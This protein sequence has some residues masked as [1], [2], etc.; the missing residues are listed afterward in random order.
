MVR[1][2][3]GEA[4]WAWRSVRGR[5]RRAVL[6]AAIVGLSLGA[7]TLV[8]STADSLVFRRVPYA[9][10]DRLV[11]I[12]SVDPR[13]GDLGDAFLSAPLLEEWRKQRD[14]FVGVQGYLTKAVFL[15]DDVGSTIVQ[16]ADVTVGLIELLGV[17][18][19][20]GRLFAPG[21]ERQS[22]P[23]PVLIA[24]Q[25]ARERF[26]DPSAAVGRRIETTA[27]PLFV[28]GVMA[29]AF[30]FP[31]STHRIWRA[32]DPRG[33]LARGFVGT[34]SI[35]RVVPAIPI[36]TLRSVVQQRSA[37]I[38]R[39]AGRANIYQASLGPLR[40]ARAQERQR[41]MFVL[42][43]AAAGCLLLIACANVASLELTTAVERA[44]RYAILLSLGASRASIGRAAVLEGGYVMLL[45]GSIGVLVAILGSVAL[46]NYL[47]ERLIAGVVN[48]VDLDGRAFVFMLAVAAATWC[49]TALPVVFFASRTK[50]ADLLKTEGFVSAGSR[51]GARL[52]GALTV[53]QVAIAVWLLT[54]G[55]L[56]ILSYLALLRNDRGF[57]TTGVA[58]LE[59]TIPPQFY[60]SLAEKRTLARELVE[61]I[62][63]LPGVLGA[64]DASA[65]PSTGMRSRFDG[66][67][68][69][70]HAP[71]DEA[72]T[73]SQFDVPVDYFSLLRIP[74]TAGRYFEQAEPPTNVIINEVLATRF[75]PAQ[76]ALG[77]RFRLRGY[78]DWYYVIGVARHVTTT[79]DATP[80]ATPALQL[81]R[82]RQ[83]EPKPPVGKGSMFSA[84]SYGLVSLSVKVD[85]PD[86][87]GDV[88][89]I[90]RQSA[91]RFKVTVELVDEMYAR[92]FE[93]VLLTTRILGSFG[94]LAFAV[95]AA[96]VYGVMM[97]LV[98]QRKREIGI[99][100]AL[101]ATRPTIQRMVLGSSVRLVTAGAVLGVSA[102]IAASKWIESQLYGTS[103]INPLVMIAVVSCVVITAL[104][105]TLHPARVAARVDP[106]VLLR[107]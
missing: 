30:R 27:E 84:A 54:A 70:S 16:C 97:L 89:Q 105:A 86:R 19:K 26:G 56:F 106:S 22:S 21:D 74:L 69:D 15:T 82:P 14:L 80:G 75:W 7:A 63:P 12:R 68:I 45:A 8:F 79:A 99:R 31:N 76:D 33:E 67:E 25:L 88:V 92:N 36:E 42:L 83:P 53:A 103:A 77:H 2:L 40:M 100:L 91:G 37:D 107:V 1:Q 58:H 23:Q 50:T 65:P 55:S 94:I 60:P 18:P 38:G 90:V 13:S 10:P 101:G 17:E 57:D 6:S 49:A 78:R 46:P 93:D 81:Y 73:V 9:D 4:L 32:L 85:S 20:W 11:E 96:G 29:D 39:A 62:R 41:T 48:R 87:L 64:V 43:L 59:V 66:I 24:E 44:R 5:A 28:V 72:F 71:M 98:T 61:R 34:I 35:T 95:A 51:L 3:A 52:R 104:V 47:P 102:A